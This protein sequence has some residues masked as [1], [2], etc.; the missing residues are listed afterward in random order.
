MFATGRVN[1]QWTVSIK[2]VW[3]SCIAK[4]TKNMKQHEATNKRDEIKHNT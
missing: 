3:N 1:V 4:T 2:I